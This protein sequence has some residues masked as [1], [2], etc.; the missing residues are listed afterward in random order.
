MNPISLQSSASSGMSMT[1]LIMV[2]GILEKQILCLQV[3]LMQIR[4][5]MLMIGKA[6]L[7]DAFMLVTIWSHGSTRNS[8]LFL[9]PQQRLNTLL[10][11]VAALL[12]MKQLLSDYGFTQ[13]TME[14]HC[15]NTS[16]INIP[17]NPVQHSSTK[18]IDIQYHFIRDLVESRV[19]SLSVMPIENQLADILTKH[20]NGGRFDSL[21]QAIGI[22]DM[23]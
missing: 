5:V 9:Y 16:A 14:I 2:F 7:I 20:L 13:R 18:H 19:I 11:V 15:D 12:W 4:R 10:L 23:S 17:K 21:R 3:T 1:L 6:P 8:L 22:C